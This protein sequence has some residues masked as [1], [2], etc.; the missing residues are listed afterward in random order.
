MKAY[1]VR[2]VKAYAAYEVGAEWYAEERPA[3]TEHYKHE[4]R[5]VELA[6]P[7][8]WRLAKS[9]GYGRLWYPPDNSSGGADLSL[10]VSWGLA[11]EKFS[12]EK[13]EE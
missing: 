1:H 8:G 7:A 10:L 6:M 13:K 12:S 4:C 5:E 11:K 2:L 9:K 3:D